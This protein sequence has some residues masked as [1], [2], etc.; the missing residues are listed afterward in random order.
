MNVRRAV[1]LTATEPEPRLFGKQVSL[2]GQLDHL[3]R[4]LGPDNVHVVLVGNRDRARPEMPY[5]LHVIDR[6]VAREQVGSLLRRVVGRPHTSLQEAALFSPRV[7]AELRRLVAEIDADVEVYDTVRLG[8]FAPHLVRS[9]RPVEQILHADDLFSVRYGAMLDHLDR[10]GSAVSSPVGEFGRLLPGPLAPLLARP[11]VYRPL[12][13]LERRLVGGSERRQPAGFARTL[14]VSEHEAA[15]L[16]ELLPDVA[17]QGLAPM[18]REPRTVPRRL[19]VTP[20]FV[21]LGGLDFA[22][23]ADGLAW[24]L[25]TA[26]EQVL[27]ELPEVRI[28]VV[29][30]RTDRGLPE[31]ASWGEHVHFQGWVDDLDDLLASCHGLLSVLRVGSGIK[32]KV[33]EALGRGLPVVATPY[34]VQGVDVDE[35]D[36]CLVCDDADGLARAMRRVADPEENARLS[37][38]ARGAWD[39]RFA[40]TVLAARYDEAFGLDVNLT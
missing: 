22:P 37:L 36:G 27:R 4:R 18:L 31:A 35:A 1:L 21:F 15:S 26:R 20:T 13:R 19:P 8:Q 32:I 7:V 10:S 3:C 5:R 38:A 29:G 17:V 39:A 40:P 28:L 2:G 16:R 34:G 6:P 25:R 14:F 12:L 24:F 33:L 11:A 23:N 9:D 30:P